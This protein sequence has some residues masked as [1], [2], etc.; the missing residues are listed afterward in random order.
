M[1]PLTAIGLV[2][3]L[4]AGALMLLKKR[5]MAQF[6][7]PAGRARQLEVIERLALGPQHTIHLVRVGARS[8]LIATAPGNCEIL[9][10][11]AELP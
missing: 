7:L 6:T 4:L 3:A 11:R 2:L 1:Q 5:G 9:E 8:V 10:S